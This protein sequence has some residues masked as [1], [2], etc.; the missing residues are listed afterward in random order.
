MA[1]DDNIVDP[2]TGSDEIVPVSI[3][4]EM[5]K[6]Y[7]DY[8]MSVIVSRALPDARDGLKPVHRRIV[9]TMNEGGYTPG[10]PYRKSARIVGDVMGKYHPHGDS[11]IYDAMVRLAQKF[12]MRVTMVDGQGNFGSMDGDS[13][14]AMRYTEARMT[15]AAASLVEDIDKDTVD[16]IP[17]Y[18]ESTSEPEVLPA[19]YPNLLIN[20]AGGIAVGMATNMLPHNPT[21]VI[22]AACALI[23][24]PELTIDELLQIVPAPDFPTGGIIMGRGGAVAAART[25]RG[26]IVVR[27]RAEVEHNHKARGRIIITEIPWQVNKARMVEQ[28]SNC[29]KEGRIEGIAEIRDESDR[30]GVRVVVEVKRDFEPDVVLNQLYRYTSLQTSYGVNALAL[31]KGRPRQM[32]LKELLVAFLDFREETIRRRTIYLLNKARDRAHIL[33]GLAVAVANVDEII[34]IIRNASN[35]DEAEQKILAK[36][37]PAEDIKPLIDLIDEPGRKVEDGVYQLSPVQARSIT[38]LRLHRLTGLERDKIRADLEEIA[39]EIAGYLEILQSRNV[40]LNLMKNELIEA[41]ER[42]GD[43]RRTEISDVGID[44]DDEDLIQREDM[45]ITVS[46]EGYI[47]RVPLSTYRAQ[48]RGGKGR[49]GMSTKD[50]DFVSQVY[51]VN[52]HT[53][54]LFFTNAGM[55][56]K[57]KVYKLPVGTPQSKGRA[58]VNLLPLNEGEVVTT[59]MPLPEDEDS[60]KDMY[61]VFATDKGY[62]RRNV[63]SDFTD[64]R[65]NGK[66]AMKLLDDE[67]LIGVIAINEGDDIILNSYLGNTIRFNYDAVRVFAGRNSRG[68]RGI[69]LADK[70]YLIS[71]SSL[72]GYVIDDTEKRDEYLRYASAKRRDEQIEVS[73]S[74]EEIQTFEENEEFVLTV[75]E[76]GFGKRTSCYEYRV[77]NRGGKGI[78]AIDMTEKT[79][80][81]IAAFPVEAEDQL[82][83]VSDGGQLIRLPL[84]NVRVAGRRTQG[85]TLFKVAD[86]EKVVSVTRLTDIDDDEALENI[87]AETGE[88]IET[89]QEIVED[90][91][92]NTEEE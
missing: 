18:D 12:S 79:G 28:V 25:G 53:P 4:D 1:L 58:L 26:S 40:L 15:R 55:V 42:F 92:K 81:V 71:M 52:T 34:A 22:N 78:S 83:M 68:V 50:E 72:K 37:W 44:I 62:V 14:A 17:N 48:K 69:R 87:D 84:V 13:A 20:G 35:R 23:D 63:L 47:K 19:R 54:V 61:A 51:M 30:H 73:L 59:L 27:G 5:R 6:S 36:K 16:F 91:T 70:D 8:A 75:T 24:N 88:V 39:T 80:P 43:E 67:H 46:S 21:E 41:R 65:S 90:D 60:W 29:A 31:D 45:V 86:K 10:R 64:V 9:Y 11:A 89:P 3:T 66:I 77:T 74:S 32:N 82:V 85:V 57:M 2:N 38:E 49:S 76:N 7:L 56:Y 33:A